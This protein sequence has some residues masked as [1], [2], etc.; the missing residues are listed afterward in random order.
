MDLCNESCLSIWSASRPGFLRG[1]YFY[2]GHYTEAFQPI[3]S[4]PAIIGTIDFYHFV[5]LSM[6]L[7]LARVTR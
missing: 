5:P 4:I 6:A 2:A 3:F 1:K 7:T